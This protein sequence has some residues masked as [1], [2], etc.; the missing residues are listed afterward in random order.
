MADH[1]TEDAVM[2]ER[3][4]SALWYHIGQIVDHETLQT[5]NNATPQFI[6]ALTELVWAQIASSSKDLE[7][8]AK[9]ANRFQI[10]TDDVLL[11]ARRNE[12]LESL[13]RGYV[14]ELRAQGKP[15][16]KAPAGKGARKR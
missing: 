10:N 14:D 5:N 11:L 3:L 13:L 12:G 2:E 15:N 7:T 1:D 16:G 8:F 4:K 6:G 9:H